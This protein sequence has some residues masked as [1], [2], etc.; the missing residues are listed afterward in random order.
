MRHWFNLAVVLLSIG[1]LFYT[2]VLLVKARIAM[3]WPAARGRIDSFRARERG[4]K[5]DAAF[6]FRKPQ[7]VYSY[8][9]SGAQYVSDR[10]SFGPDVYQ[11]GPD[12]RADQ[13]RPGAVVTVFY[14]PAHPHRS[15]L[16][17]GIHSRFFLHVVVAT[18]L[19]FAGFTLL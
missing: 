7:V 12:T 14:D 5:Y 11:E 6:G 18:A 4:G 16:V 19:L 17:R 15:V 8:Q 13:Y 2:V 10:L 3:T 9:V 1:W